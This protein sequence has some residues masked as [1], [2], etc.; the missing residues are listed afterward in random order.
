MSPL[1]DADARA[2]I[3]TDTAA[4]LF[5]DAGAGS[6]KTRSLVDRVR[7]LVLDGRVPLS[8]IAAVTFTEKAGSELRDRLRDAFESVYRDERQARRQAGS[9]DD[10][11]APDSRERLAADAL[12]D[13]DGAAIGTLHSFAQRILTTHP[14]EAGLPPLVEVLDEVAS[15]VAFDARWSV[16]QRE[17]LDEESLAQPVRLALAAGVKLDHLRSLARAFQSDWDLIEDRVL[18]QGPPD[19]ALPDAVDLVAEARAIA[20]R[21]DECTD[22]SDLFL[23]R[24]AALASWAEQYGD[25]TDP[26]T[27][28]AGL[29]AAKDL[30]WGGGGRQANWPG[31]LKEIRDAAKEWQSRAASALGDFTEASLRPL[32]YWIATH[33]RDDAQARAAEGRLEFHD[34]LV[35]TRDLLRRDGAVRSA[36][37]EQ[38]RRLLLDEFQ[39]TDP[40]QIEIAVRIAGG[41]DASAADWQDVEVPA[42]SIFVV[43]DPKQSIYRFR[44]A[45]IGTYL[46][47]QEWLGNDPVTLDSNFRTVE[48]I[49]E[50]VNAVFGTVI[51]PVEEGQPEYVSLA[52][53]RSY[54]GVGPPVAVVGAE[55]HPDKP[56]AAM[57]R[58]RE[59]ADVAG[60]I[61]RA[62]AEGWTTC[63]PRTDE[64]RPLRLGDIAILVPARTS[65]P[66]LEDALDAAG[67]GYRAESSS[68]VYQAAEVRDLLATARVIADPS[69]LLSCVTALRSPLFGCGD[70]DLW[71]WKRDGGSF[72]ILARFADER[73]WHPVAQGLAYLSR[74]HYD[75]RWMTPSEMLGAIVADRRMLEVAATG[76][77]A[78]DQWRRLRFVVDQA[79]AWSEA[80]HGGLRAY[81]AWAA[82]Q[83]EE[84]ARVAEAVLPE[85]DVDAVRVMTVHAAKGL[86]FP[87]VVLS[88]MSS[89]PNSPSGVRLLWTASGYEVKLTKNVQT[90]DFEHVAP[91]DE[92]MDGYERRRLLYVATTRARDHLVVSLHRKDGGGTT[93]ADIL[94]GA[95]A[96]TDVESLGG[97]A[98][99]GEVASRPAVD[100]AE[101]PEWSAWLAS[102][103][104]ARER[105]RR[106][107]AV[108]ASGLEGTEPAAALDPAVAEE[109]PGSA[110]GARD[111]ELPPWSKGRYGSAVGRAVHAVLQSIDL[112]T[113]DG[114]DG[115]VAAQCA[116]E[117]VTEHADV[118]RALVESALASEPVRRAA[119]RP[120][121]RE[122]YV[123][124]LQ[125]DGTVLEGFVDL[126][127][128][129]DGGTLVIVDYKTDA[130]PAA[131]IGARTAYYAPQLA[132]YEQ[133][134]AE[135]T[136]AKVSARGLFLHPDSMAVEGE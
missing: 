119:A 136:A 117:G 132:A 78:R 28:L 88:G 37:Q 79:R 129:D 43:G 86:E 36:L 57:M 87:M 32:A 67:I 6:G 10:E 4:T 1:T 18:S 61:G 91:I 105:S 97:V 58:E 77:R 33:V 23:P 131:A 24:L 94:A 38:Y 34:L 12:D 75:A 115:A 5:V 76:P 41:A 127:Y 100:I 98:V 118:V 15:S 134:I 51:T 107:S 48:P 60:V 20:A 99:V 3:E 66:F 103:T 128:R 21:A 22:D 30:K 47:T 9:G 96:A 40:I 56:N 63:D 135:A 102:I 35:V 92:Q 46:R 54:S 82:R 130:I 74:L 122:P 52:A 17:L 50:W 111:V 11:P 71:T 26:E 116:A 29:L 70:D 65:L 114:L 121:W 62:I 113:G 95:G 112:A 16:L 101:L 19:P 53:T 104:E 125:D 110:K 80:E 85:S 72:N 27:Q 120:H 90:N 133:A 8:N 68:L 31:T 73:A 84:T 25:A 89:R 49:V 59:A 14:I 39:D 55:S 42:G 106:V 2:R 64:W 83:G 44:R 81:L 126:V 123:G 7:T 124:I 45:D 108:S 93:N 109:T 13:L 69:D